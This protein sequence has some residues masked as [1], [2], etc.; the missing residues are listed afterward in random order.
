[1]TDE[2]M[3]EKLSALVDNE[4]DELEE[5]RVFAA[6]ESN[7][8]LR[9][10]WQRYHLVRAILQGDLSAAAAPDVSEE[11]AKRIA[12]DPSAA[13]L[14]QTHKAIR[15]VGTLAIAAS[16]AAI[17]IVGVQ[18]LNQP[19]PTP[20]P[21]VAASNPAPEVAVRAVASSTTNAGDEET[22]N[23]LNAYLVQHE[24]FS[25]TPGIGGMMS[26]VRAVSIDKD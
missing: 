22:V 23:A 12:G 11:I 3:K 6:L 14:F 15:F 10:T 2:H 5:R 9:Q 1:M 21:L 17:A 7:A 4:L 20:L 13:S 8:P 25:S 26:Y 16:V 18:W 24:E 19:T